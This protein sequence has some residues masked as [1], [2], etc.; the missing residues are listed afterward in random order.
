MESETKAVRGKWMD[1]VLEEV[2]GEGDGEGEEEAK[3]GRDKG[4][5]GPWRNLLMIGHRGLLDKRS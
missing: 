2:E 5:G 4:Q 1:D 3:K